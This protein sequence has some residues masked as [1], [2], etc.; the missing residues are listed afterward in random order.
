MKNKLITLLLCVTVSCTLLGGCQTSSGSTQNSST[1]SSSSVDTD[2]KTSDSTQ[3]ENTQDDN[4]I[5]G[6]VTAIDGNTITLA[7]GERA[8][9]PDGDFTPPENGEKPSTTGGNDTLQ[10]G[11]SDETA[12]SGEDAAVSA[13]G[14]NAGTT[15][16]GDEASTP[17]SDDNA[18]TSASNDNSGTPPSGDNDG[19]P[20]SGG[21]M[22]P[23]GL[24]LTG[25]EKE[26]TIDDDTK[27]TKDSMG[28]SSDAPVEDI[29]E[30]SI[31]T[32]VM[33]GDTVVSVTIS[34]FGGGNGGG[35]D[36]NGGGPGGGMNG[37][38]EEA[39]DLN[40]SKTIDGTEETASGDTV[41]SITAEENTILAKN[42]GSLKLDNGTLDKAGDSSNADQSNFYA[43]NAIFAV[44]QGST[45]T[46]SNTTLTS[47]AEGSNA[48]F[49][50]GENASVTVDTVTIHTKGDSSRG[51][52]ATYNGTIIATNVDITTEGAHCA[53]VATDRGEGTMTVDGGTLSASG[54]GSPCIYSTG[55]ITASNITGTATGSQAAVVEGKN[56]ITLNSC[57]LTGAGEN[58]IMLYQS[59]SGDAAEGTASLHASD[60]VISSTS[61][62]PFFY[63]TNTQAEATLQNTT[64]N[65]SSG[66]LVNAAGNDTNNWGTP[67]SNGG[68][69]QLTGIKQTFEGD[70]ICDSISTVSVCLTDSSVFK[71]A[72][73]EENTAKEINLSLDSTSTWEVTKTSYLTTLTNDDTSCSNIISNG[74]TIYYDSSQEA[75]KWLNNETIF[76]EDGGSIAPMA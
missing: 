59:T 35:P 48:I 63:I 28:Q 60:S 4:A 21:G 6:Q 61:E 53:P 16:S 73:N 52:D 62:G 12:A 7:L 32:V 44:T 11:A 46:I 64:L 1:S 9:R 39:P 14:D 47:D 24:T 43:L 37:G 75:N 17:S 18:G 19:T 25:E 68:T 65:Y 71:G 34:A 8:S 15:A 33:D 3:S 13:S 67:G 5:T 58:G 45:A 31:L 50:T 49:A 41:S 70:I 30:G 66:I 40:G 38:T 23:G 69:F 2:D 22:G 26:I 72:V 10:T 54:D 51:L 20:P 56:S 57:D 36:G 29:T 42:G 27:I 55:N 74:N 76:L